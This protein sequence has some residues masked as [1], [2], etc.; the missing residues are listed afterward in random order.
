V[1]NSKATH[2]DGRHRR[3]RRLAWLLIVV[4]A[5]GCSSSKKAGSPS[6]PTSAAASTATTQPTASA[7]ADADVSEIKAAFVKFFD[8]KTSVTESVAVIQDGAAF[9]DTLEQQARTNAA[10]NASAT[11]SKVV[12]DSPNR[13]SVVY[14]IL[15]SGSPLLANVTG[16]AVRENGKW[17]V[18]GATFCALLT[19][20]GAPPPVCSQ[21]AATSLPG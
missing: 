2:P 7:L 21:P 10:Q 6:S 8:S 18:A 1:I 11:V 5:A 12:G 16:F 3:A 19:L 4:A 17:K 9:K 15:Q 14:T 13:A 20:Q